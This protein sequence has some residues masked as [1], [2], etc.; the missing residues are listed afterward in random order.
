VTSGGSLAGFLTYRGS[1]NRLDLV[2]TEILP[3]YEGK[4]LAAQLV[5]QALDDVR[6][7]GRQ[8]VPSCSYVAKFVQRHPQYQDLVEP[9]S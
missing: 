8:V 6:A 5:G 4:G 7:S 3:E 2:H 9:A 1:E